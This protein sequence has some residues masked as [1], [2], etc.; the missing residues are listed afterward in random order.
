[1]NWT[2]YQ[3]NII[4]HYHCRIGPW[5]Q[6]SAPLF[7]PT[8]SDLVSMNLLGPIPQAEHI[9]AYETTERGKALV[10]MWCSTP[11]PEQ[12]FFDPRF[13]DRHGAVGC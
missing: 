5:P 9:H 3:I 11:L 13:E 10:E 12:K 8:V 2:P 4:M 6:Y 7:E 1:M